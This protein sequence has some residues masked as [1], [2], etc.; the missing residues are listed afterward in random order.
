MSPALAGA[1]AGLAEVGLLTAEMGES[2]PGE[3]PWVFAY[4]I[5]RKEIWW[6]GD[7]PTWVNDGEALLQAHLQREVAARLFG[8]RQSF[9]EGWESGCY[10][11]AVGPDP[12]VATW[13]YADSPALALSL[14][15][16]AA[17]G[18]PAGAGAS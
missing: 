16:L 11:A 17:L 1:L 12:D 2:G 15:L 6:G 14:A 18:A 9:D 13:V 4:R 7:Q 3:E 5:G 8:Y 10:G